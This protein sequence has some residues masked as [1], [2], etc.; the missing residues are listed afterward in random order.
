MYHRRIV[1]FFGSRKY[2]LRSL[3][4]DLQGLST[5]DESS[6]VSAANDTDVELQTLPSPSS[7][8]LKPHDASVDAIKRTF[9]STLARGIFSLCFSEC[10]TLFLLLMFQA[11]DVLHAQTRLLNWRISLF[12][13]LTLIVVLIPLAY[14][15][16][17]SYRSASGLQGLQKPTPVRLFLAA[18][19]VALSLFLLSF[20]PL[21]AG[22]SSTG[23]ANVVLARL[24]VVGT[25]ILGL[26]SGFGAVE[27]GWKF[28]PLLSR[29]S[30]PAPTDE[31]V[32][33]AEDG[34]RRVRDDLAERRKAVARLEATSPQKQSWL[35]SV[36]PN[37][38]GDNR[39][40]AMQEI[41]GLEA[42]E[43][44][45]ARNLAGLK[46]QRQDAK[47]SKTLAGRVLNV[48]GGV[49][50]IYCV[51]RIFVAIGNLILPS[52][53]GGS[54]GSTES[55]GG[56]RTDFITIL[57]AYLI[58]FIP[59]VHLEHDAIVLISRQISLALVGIIIL[60]SVRLVLRGVARALRVTSRNLGASL[61]LLML[62]Q[63]MGI[64]LLSTLVQLRTSFPPPLSRT[65][66]VADVVEINLFSTL[67]EYQVFGA[68]FDGSFLMSAGVSALVRW[69][70][71][72]INSV[73]V[74]DGS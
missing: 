34:L 3:Y 31:Q 28:L 39:N 2:L 8:T 30:K 55:D 33:R 42:L 60:S 71:Q 50:A 37:F 66:A 16:V 4:H 67:P 45:M 29:T 9:H 5:E 25:V 52:G 7:A 46:R 17:L 36:V 64:Y 23:T 40:N 18:C 72:K 47:F 43:G 22:V 44:Q 38:R 56:P 48:G 54:T 13:L 14:S 63:L 19:P 10:C 73:G 62:A 51:Y 35:T 6:I 57:L 11:L 59:K 27:N 1:L 58:S 26:L 65:D 32:S 53:R 20:V 12:L 21:P 24:T 15:L 41:A 49:F 70:N 69:F 74:M 61:M 68:V